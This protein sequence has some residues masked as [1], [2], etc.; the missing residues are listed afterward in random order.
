MPR[1]AA[2]TQGEPGTGWSRMVVSSC[3]DP[4]PARQARSMHVSRWVGAVVLVGPPAAAPEQ[5]SVPRVVRGDAALRERDQPPGMD[6]V[7]RE[8]AA[9]LVHRESGSRRGLEDRPA[10]ADPGERIVDLLRA[11]QVPAVHRFPDV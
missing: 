6:E 10:I 2:G 8:E 9:K 7:P 4:T 3:P 11:Q 1:S 5:G